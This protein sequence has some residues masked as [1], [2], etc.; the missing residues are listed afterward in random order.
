[1]KTPKMTKEV[2]YHAICQ[3]KREFN[4]EE[5]FANYPN[6]FIEMHA[7]IRSLTFDQKP[8]YD[9]IRKL[10]KVMMRNGGFTSK[11]EFEWLRRGSR[12]MQTGTL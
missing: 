3:A 2:W 12:Y 7:Y 4:V 11:T 9:Y 5:Y 10:L 1:M 8:D 6:E